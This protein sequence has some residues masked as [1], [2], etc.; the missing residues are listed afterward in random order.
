MRLR[1]FLSVVLLS[2]GTAL[3][4]G[5]AFENE[6]GIVDENQRKELWKQ[7]EAANK[8]SLPKTAVDLLEKIYESAITDEE[9]PEAV[10]ALAQK[11][12][13]EGNQSQPAV[14]YVIRK[15]G[16][17]MDSLPAKVQPIM[18]VVLANY[19]FSYYQNNRWRFAQRSQTGQAPSEDF[20]TWDL[21]RLLEEV[22]R[23]FTDALASS[24]ELKTIPIADYD[25]L[26]TKGNVSDLY[27]PTLF[28][29]VAFQAIS[30][31]TLDEQ[32]V[33]KKGAFDLTAD[34]PIFA[35]REQFLKWDT[36]ELDGESYL[37]KALGLLQELLK[38]HEQDK[39]STALL[40]A[41][42]HRL[43]F[44]NQVAVGAEK[45]ARYKAA[46][47]RFSD[48]HDDHPL[49]STALH[50]LASAFRGENEL[51]KAH[52]IANK[53]QAR[54]PESIGGKLCF[55]LIQ[56]IEAARLQ[57]ST[58]RVWS[59]VEN[60]IDVS[61]RNLDKVH[62]RLYE[63][64]YQNWSW[65]NK[66]TAE[67]L[68][69]RPL[70]QLANKRM[71]KEWSRDL[72]KT[73]DFQQRLEKLPV[74]FRD[75]SSGCYLLVASADKDFSETKNVVSA[76]E[77]WVS[78]IAVVSR[79]ER[80]EKQIAGQVLDN[81]SGKAIAGANVQVS[82]WVRDGR[83][84]R[85]VELDAGKTDQ[86][87][88]FR[89]NCRQNSNHRIIIRSGDQTFG[90]I[91]NSYKYSSSNRYSRNFEQT[92]FFT[93][94]AIY[95]PGQTVNFKGI[96]IF[97]NQKRNDYKTI[98]NRNV[99]VS[100]YDSNNQEVEKLE[101]RTNEFG[102][103]SGS[104]VA[105]SD[106][107]TGAMR[108]QVTGGPNG[109]KS[110]RVE[111]Y[112]RPKFFVEIEKPEESFNLN[113]VVTVKGK[114]SAYTGAPIDGAKI[115]W[116]VVREVRYPD[117]WM[118]R[119][120]WNPPTSQPQEIDN[121]ES[122]TEIDGTFSVQFTA[123]PDL[124]VDR[125]GQPVFSY[126]VYA[127]VTD[128]VGETRSAQTRVQLGYTSL[129]ASLSC[130][131]WQQADKPIKLNLTTT[132]LD[133][134]GIA[135]SGTLRV[136]RLKP[137]KK[138]QRAKLTPTF[139]RFGNMA[140]QQSNDMSKI[141]SWPLGEQ[142]SDIEF[143]T[144]ADG[145]SQKELE[146]ESGAYKV[147]FETR[148]KSGNK[149]TAEK[150]VTVLAIGGD[151][152]DIRVPHHFQVKNQSV[153]VGEKFQAFWGTGY[154]TGQAF[155][156]L[157]H[158]GNVLKSYWTEAGQTQTI[159]DMDVTE[160]LRGGFFVRLTYV[161][162]NRAYTESRRIMV[163]WSNK[164]LNIKWERFVS[165]LEPG[166]K[167]TW[168]AVV[169]GPDAE[170]RTAE[171]V[172]TMYDA[173][174]DAYAANVWPGSFNV[175]YQD[176]ST[177]RLSFQNEYGQLRGWVNN[178]RYR[179]KSV[180]NV[181]YR[182]F[183]GN[184]VPPVLQTAT[185]FSQVNNRFAAGG[186]MLSARAPRGKL[187][188]LDKFGLDAPAALAETRS[189][190]LAQ[191]SGIEAEQRQQNG[192]AT[193]SNVDLSKVSARK[194]LNETAFFFPNLTV[195]QDG[196]VRIEFEV[197]EA[198]TQWKILGFAHDNELRT[199]LLTDEAVTS[200][201]LMVQPNPPRF[202]REG[203]SLEFSVKVSNQSATR[204]TGKIRLSFADARDESGM[205][206]K[207]NNVE[208]EKAFDI[209]AGQ[210][211]SL[212]W[213]LE[214]PDFVGVLTYKAVG[215]TERLSDGEEGF[216]PVLS[217]R[218]LV[219]ESLPLPIRGNQSRDFKF[220]RLK[221]IEESDSLVSQSFTV[222]MASNPA[223]YAVLSL[224][225]LMEYP[226]QC[227]EQV[228]NRLYANSIGGHIVNS[229]PKI[230]RIFEQWRGTDALDSPLEKNE[231]IRNVLIAES[232]W[233]R[234]AK[235]ESHSR[236]NVAILF[237]KNRLESESRIALNRLKQMQKSD[238][239]WPWFPGGRA[240]D[241]I[242]LYVTTGFGR[243]RH[244]GVNVD[245]SP[246]V[247]ALDRLDNW[248]Y[249]THQRILQTGDPNQNHLTAQ[250]CLYLYGRSF[251]LKDMAIKPKYK[252]AVDYFQG[253]AKKYWP[254]L[255]NRQSQGHL[256]IGL[257]R[258]GDLETPKEIMKSLTERSQSSDEL[259]MYWQE[260][261][262]TWWWYR[263]P[264]E[265]Q[266][267]MIEAFDEVAG[268]AAKVEECKIWL[269]KQK[270]TQNWKT[271]KATAD[272]IYALL[273]RGTDQLSSSKLVNVSLG[274]ELL[275]PAKVEA[276]TGFYEKKYIRNEIRPEFNQIN[277]TKDDDG[278]AWGSVHWQYLEDVGKI[279]PY[280]GTPLT[281]KKGLFIKKNTDRGPVIE[282]VEGAVEVGD[283]LVTRVE[284]RVDRDMEYVHLKDYRGSGTEPVN[285]L[286][287]YK[288]QDGLA[289]YESTKDT[290][291]HFFID[292]LPRGTYVFEYSVR[293][294]HRGQYETG[295]AELQCM[296]AP[297]Y[298][299]HSNSV[300]IDVR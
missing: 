216:L 47:Q 7:V 38:F 258:F 223:W 228:F 26:L 264:I 34:S 295:I 300:K 25:I 181:S 269:L 158:R 234:D 12:L 187:R 248:I 284:I 146:L 292:Y 142:V 31:Y 171:M 143:K 286:S 288:Y 198:L 67:N 165:K 69:N 66:R 55:N 71:V 204:Q 74:E 266:S 50:Q 36:S 91:D 94:R 109:A 43:G 217:K 232:P 182:K 9:Y 285:V 106:R 242:T 57:I 87:G 199:A 208:L 278:V 16:A 157:V 90:Y 89:F 201:D 213:K 81:V 177:N 88:F 124:S 85:S 1:F 196:K 98:A 11:Y 100:I 105:P 149:V 111:E 58:E 60:S 183:D 125:D 276:G 19:F 194:N 270:Q 70:S 95:R 173:S 119:Y 10:R 279:T 233:L 2:V 162:E 5:S 4:A 251:F 167:V 86:N 184:V 193:A 252:S 52:E 185:Y 82:A 195:D 298:N 41:D 263:A 250:I 212:F 274:G 240:N 209:P 175:F 99:V 225:Y 179:S 139:N 110:F 108:I 154:S 222:Q 271:T 128:T 112:K 21:A 260:D 166:G 163:P 141:G 256:A 262:A 96:C 79:D 291:S 46:L 190:S 227:S 137:P 203:D 104:F 169:S 207:L 268:D 63:F 45:S 101:F 289:Y 73:D 259:G 245:I 117:W 37:V 18:K 160:K 103:F 77:I 14:P 280:E 28:D 6:G 13:T 180:R 51:L 136:Y 129:Q 48:Q 23:L 120:W 200:K 59:T 230:E 210:S 62:F 161:R 123:D 214:V 131:D 153:E 273:M 241:Y 151:K 49:S 267:L 113:D 24:E 202:L 246:A 65:G 299:S 32:I 30:F 135:T 215:G 186:E 22:D 206:E 68:G 148:D 178:L 221:L 235:D 297:E 3:F 39:D 93:D 138:I 236:R 144:E 29:F 249:E 176:Y 116:R 244:L 192:P 80:G 15:L 253:Q 277:V 156:E 188:G 140:N 145:D 150:P 17:D 224:P 172:A 126:A 147:V 189:L 294:Q 239:S 159:I 155:V 97:S 84:S 121:G 33:R 8:K 254:D 44:G 115:K 35:S 243:L 283:E 127:D 107:A 56:Q 20:A 53:G 92:V 229:N 130:E 231:D 164:K 293:V 296:Y 61:Y 75:L 265:T 237:D 226:H 281:L 191:E 247:A 78:K 275:R 64:D 152:F 255:G 218:I 54:F 170:R 27:R 133:G 83:N 102:S 40:D 290:A 219:T 257:K 42:L 114:A 118:W 197:P 122:T 174:L 134:K 132:T 282:P 211:K 272:A 76:K 287:R 220:D 168:T 238:G 261:G 72:P 205:D